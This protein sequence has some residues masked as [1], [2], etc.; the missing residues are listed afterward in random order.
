MCA[1][2]LHFGRAAPFIYTVPYKVDTSRVLT[3]EQAGARLS[4]CEPLKWDYL[5][6]GENETIYYA[7][8]RMGKCGCREYV[9]AVRA[10]CH[11]LVKMIHYH[12]CACLLVSTSSY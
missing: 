7:D 3:L 5:Y 11:Y 4:V 9:R 1:Y 2:N 6:C 8:R 10:G 12:V